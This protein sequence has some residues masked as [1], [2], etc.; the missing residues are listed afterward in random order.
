MH[1]V[2]PGENSLPMDIVVYETFKDVQLS[3]NIVI[4][5]IDHNKLNNNID[6]LETVT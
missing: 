1:A 4:N 3:S 6:N 2:C 5:H